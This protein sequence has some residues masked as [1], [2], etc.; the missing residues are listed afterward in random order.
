MPLMYLN[1]KDVKVQTPYIGQNISPIKVSVPILSGSVDI[2][3]GFS[4]GKELVYIP[5]NSILMRHDNLYQVKI[6]PN[7]QIEISS[8]FGY[9]KDGISMFR[10]KEGKLEKELS[11]REM[12]NKKFRF[13]GLSINL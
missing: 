13:V 2:A 11:F 9:H 6:E 3:F 10:L 5:N 7:K 12:K 1:K 8:E 4:N